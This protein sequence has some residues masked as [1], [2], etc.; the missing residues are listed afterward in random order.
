MGKDPCTSDLSFLSAS[1]SLSFTTKCSY[2]VYIDLDGCWVLWRSSAS[3]HS[4]PWVWQRPWLCRHPLRSRRV[5]P[6]AAGK[7]LAEDLVKCHRIIPTS[8]QTLACCWHGRRSSKGRQPVSSQ[9]KI[10]GLLMAREP[11][12]VVR[13]FCCDNEFIY[14]L[15]DPSENLKKDNLLYSTAFWQKLCD[16]HWNASGG[17]NPSP[18]TLHRLV[19]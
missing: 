8:D 6:A 17:I 19:C 14:D 1:S 5:H 15:M 11:N 7:P 12:T 3:V 13:R 4:A 10:Q 9:L 2:T 16:W 18:C